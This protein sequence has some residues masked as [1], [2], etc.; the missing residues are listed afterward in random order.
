M[1][2]K[3]AC[4]LLFILLS[5][6]L[7]LS[8]SLIT[9]VTPCNDF[10][11]ACTLRRHFLQHYHAYDKFNYTKYEDVKVVKKLNKTPKNFFFKPPNTMC[12]F[13]YDRNR[14]RKSKL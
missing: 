13:T 3:S 7:R 12:V 9:A 2:M 14:A 11:A 8:N 6:K 10:S 1:K 4:S 5:N